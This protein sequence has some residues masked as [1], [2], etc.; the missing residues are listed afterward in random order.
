MC[1]V[2]WYQLILTTQIASHR[3]WNGT[4]CS[5][6]CS[7]INCSVTILFIHMII[8]NSCCVRSTF[9]RD[10]NYVQLSKDYEFTSKSVGS[11]LPVTRR[12]ALAVSLSVSK[13]V[14]LSLLQLSDRLFHS[15]APM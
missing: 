1:S 5:N 13:V 7:K 15:L 3:L 2:C 9:V 14:L 10:Y 4:N 12:I 6:V 11:I 8:E